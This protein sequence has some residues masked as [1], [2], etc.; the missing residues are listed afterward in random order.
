MIPLRNLKRFINKS[1]KQP[2]YAFTVAMKR[3]KSYA[4][5]S[6]GSGKACSPE[7]ITLF[8]THRCNLRCKMCGQWGERGVT[9]KGEAGSAMSELPPEQIKKV[10]DELSHFLPNIT[11]FGGEPL[12]YPQCERII[13][14]I[15]GHKMHCLV[16]T[17]GFL[18]EE[19]ARELVESGLDELNVSLDGA[20]ELHDNIRGMPGLFDKITNGLKKVQA[21]K[22]QMGRHKPL[23]NLQCTINRDNYN[24]L[25]QLLEVARLVQA[26]SLTF[27]NLIFISRPLKEEQ[28]EFDRRF[29]C[30]SSGW[31]GFIFDPG[32]DPQVLYEKIK[33]IR[34]GRYKFNIDFYPN[35]SSKA[36]LHYYT[37]EKY[38]P[39]GYPKRC[40]SPWVVAYVFPD[41]EIRPCLN[42][43]YSFG[44]IKSSAFMQAWNS[45]QALRYRKALKNQRIFPACARCTELYR[46]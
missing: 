40:L 44:N 8:L 6:F 21:I 36:L 31:E 20:S 32:I 14:Y 17:N 16:I 37:N 34:Q 42:S 28:D 46:Y 38:A 5:Y 10:I 30:E 3:M 18:L 11:L 2:G 22:K 12:L 45:P 19:L 4:S 24:Y 41:A 1:L 29:G 35:F 15:K 9:R 7:A 26:D 43:S 27:H 39:E 13:R 23:L 33:K 25:E